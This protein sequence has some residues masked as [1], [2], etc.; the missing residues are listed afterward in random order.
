MSIPSESV[1]QSG[2]TEGG[3]GS[4]A[5]CLHLS[6]VL[7]LLNDSQKAINRQRQ[8]ALGASGQEYFYAFRIDRELSG[9][10]QAAIGLVRKIFQQG[11]VRELSILNSPGDI[12]ASRFIRFPFSCYTP[13]GEVGNLRLIRNSIARFALVM[14]NIYHILGFDVE[15]LGLDLERIL[16]CENVED[17]FAMASIGRVACAATYSFVLYSEVDLKEATQWAKQFI[18]FLKTS[19]VTGYN[20]QYKPRKYFTPYGEYASLWESLSRLRFFL[21]GISYADFRTAPRFLVK[22]LTSLITDT[23]PVSAGAGQQQISLRS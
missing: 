16:Q 18:A 10:E 4:E 2:R 15:C 19:I 1:I 11:F 14:E 12:I 7:P 13:N 22:F 5:T 3:H 8:E 6:V 9:R 17:G 21:M 23:Y 20:R